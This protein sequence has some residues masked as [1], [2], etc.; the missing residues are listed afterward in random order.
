MT[1]SVQIRKEHLAVKLFL[2]IFFT[3]A[4]LGAYFKDREGKTFGDKAYS[5]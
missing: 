2:D 3:Y 1:I 4:R 5:F